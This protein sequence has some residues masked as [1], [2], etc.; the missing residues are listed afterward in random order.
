MFYVQFN[1]PKDR[2][3]FQMLIQLAELNILQD[4]ND[5]PILMQ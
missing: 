5:S 4:I 1:L 2:S 3:F